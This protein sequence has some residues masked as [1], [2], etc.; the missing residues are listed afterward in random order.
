MPTFVYRAVG[1]SGRVVRGKMQA[2]DENELAHY[3]EQSKLEVIDARENKDKK[4]GSGSLRLSF[5]RRV[6]AAFCSNVNELLKAGVEFPEALA[7]I[8]ASTSDPEL[9]R[10]LS[11]ICGAMADGKGVA[12]AFGAFPALFSPV[13]VALVA[14][15]ERSGDMVGVFGYLATMTQS[16]M[17]THRRL[18]KALR[19]PL[20]LLLT[21]GSAVVFM[22][23]M[24]MPQVAIFL[25]GLGGTLPLASRV[26]V[27]V[28]QGA[29]AYGMPVFAALMLAVVLF[30]VLR[31]F[32]PPFRAASDGVLAGAPVLG[33]IIVKTEVARFARSFSILF[34]SGCDAADCLAL[35]GKVMSNM[36][37][38][39]RA[40]DAR[41][42]LVHG[43][44]LSLALERVF[45]SYALGVVRTGERS[46]NIAKSL[47]DIAHTYDAEAGYAVDT[48]IGVLEPGLTLV[49]GAVLAWTVAAVVAPLYGS[50]SVLG[51]RM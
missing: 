17:E 23:A 37:L 29:A 14:A 42:R 36:S 32:F 9:G 12:S 43:A 25:D 45:P 15:G 10:A 6:L 31:R 26:L 38:Q 35:A 48:F 2:A 22:M 4:A 19:Y 51:G 46:G 11:Q 24:V 13:F 50:L 5:S 33:N 41:V 30:F 27:A 8:Q 7:T 18:A 28:S 40:E 47:E 49:I 44:P 3:L 39:H 20:F 16:D 21:A 1:P 34:K